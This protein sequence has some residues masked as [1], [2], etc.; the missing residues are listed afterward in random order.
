MPSRPKILN[1]EDDASG[2][3]ALTTIL[4]LNNFTVIEAASGAEGLRRARADEPDLILLDINLPDMD[5]FEVCR[6]LKAD[7]ATARIPV[8]HITASYRDSTYV[9]RGLE[10]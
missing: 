7:S 10:S 4:A 8:M 1:V 9:A 3:F 5:G 2:R 6:Q